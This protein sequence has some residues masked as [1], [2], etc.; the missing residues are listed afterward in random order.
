M[1]R[2]II[3]AAAALTSASFAL[4]EWDPDF[5]YLVDE[6]L[7]YEGIPPYIGGAVVAYNRDVVADTIGDKV[8]VHIAYTA[9]FADYAD[10]YYQI[11]Y[12]RGFYDTNIGPQSFAWDTDAEV[13]TGASDSKF[14]MQPTISVDREHRLWV[15]WSDSSECDE[16]SGRWENIEIYAQ[17]ACYEPTAE[18]WLWG[19]GPFR[20]S[21]GNGYSDCAVALPRVGYE[22]YPHTFLFWRDGRDDEGFSERTDIYGDA[23]NG[24][25][26]FDP[27]YNC[28]VAINGGLTPFSMYTVA[29]T[30]IDAACDDGDNFH[31]VWLDKRNDDDHF[32]VYYK[33]R[34]AQGAWEPEYALRDATGGGMT[35]A[36]REPKICVIN[37][38]GVG[39]ALDLCVMVRGYASKPPHMYVYDHV[40][41]NWHYVDRAQVDFGSPW[42][43]ALASERGNGVIHTVF[44][45]PRLYSSGNEVYYRRGNISG[46]PP[47]VSW[48]PGAK[49]TVQNNVDDKN[50]FQFSSLSLDS[51]GVLH[52]VYRYDGYPANPRPTSVRYEND[53]G[54]HYVGGFDKG[55]PP[56][57]AA[58]PSPGD[59]SPLTPADNAGL[60]P[61]AGEYD[62]PY[63]G[64]YDSPTAGKYI[65]PLDSA[66]GAPEAPGD[67]SLS[68]AAATPAGLG[69]DSLSPS[70]AASGFEPG[71]PLVAAPAS[72]LSCNPNPV[73][74]AAKITFNLQKLSRVKLA[75]Y[76]LSGRRVATLA[77][78]PYAAGEHVANWSTD[79]I[80]SGIY[81]YRLEAGDNAVTKKLVVAK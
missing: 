55:S 70:A 81:L 74:S 41:C 1:R 6:E 4:A 58:P 65:S 22:Q 44:V 25:Y 49:E 26:A 12:R 28:H 45:A 19:A 79:G 18:N 52:T 10:N 57:A 69:G 39:P 36:E 8:Y 43:G 37:M 29:N 80:P 50:K 35:F 67:D 11:K 2:Y 14:K 73:T 9:C 7:Y 13:I 61:R 64:E 51:E 47:Q 54:S 42:T 3:A 24:Y 30:A 23:V 62:Y 46:V 66:S 16:E 78:G 5:N 27:H 38:S 33:A 59:A 17:T 31:L 53:G 32:Y 76:D 68:P 63:A 56:T 60:S 20:V 71:V 21:A 77:D 48:Y 34:T 75:V 72:P 40:G 15:F